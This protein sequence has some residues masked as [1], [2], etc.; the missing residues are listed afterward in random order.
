M[1]LPQ[2]SLSTEQ[3]GSTRRFQS[4]TSAALSDD[5]P[6]PDPSDH[7]IR[8]RVYPTPTSATPSRSPKESDLRLVSQSGF[9][10]STPD[11]IW[12]PGSVPDQ[13]SGLRI[14]LAQAGE[15]LHPTLLPRPQAT[16]FRVVG[17]SHELFI[18][19]EVEG[20]LWV[21][22]QHAAHE[23]VVYEQVLAALH[24][25]KG[26]SQALLLPVTFDLEASART[27]L[28]ELQDYLTT[29]GFDIR[30]FGGKTFQVQAAPPYFRPADTPDL[31]TDLVQARADGRSENSIAAKQEDLAA[32]VACKVKSVKAGQTLTPEPMRA[33]VM[34]LLA[35]QSPF[36]CPHGRPTMVR[37]SVRH[38][39]GQFDRR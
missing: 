19:V 25:R 22:D 14:P 21:I 27:A 17:Q 1:E 37:M 31:I 28:D 33:L 5:I 24:D 35:C 3:I 12:T 2:A 20:E 29:L 7:P 9:Q 26:E 8:G 6:T 36:A 13:P 18:L 34:S 11:S 30:P 16:A 32:R 10:E 38:L 23:R 4:S 39:E 15:P